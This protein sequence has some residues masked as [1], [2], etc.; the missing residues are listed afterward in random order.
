M[1]IFIKGD[2]TPFF[3]GIW[4]KQGFLLGVLP[5]FFALLVKKGILSFLSWYNPSVKSSAV[6]IVRSSPANSKTDVVEIYFPFASRLKNGLSR[7]SIIG[8]S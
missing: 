3:R 8:F 6:E 7:I 4:A 1:K 5:L 2:F